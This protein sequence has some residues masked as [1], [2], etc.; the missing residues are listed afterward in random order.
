ML[1]EADNVSQPQG[2]PHRR[3]FVGAGLDLTLWTGP[4]KGFQGFQICYRL[5]GG[6]KVLTFQEGDGYSHHNL[7]DGESSCG[8]FKQ[9]PL[10]VPDGVLDRD[11]LLARFLEEAAELE[12]P[13]LN[14][15]AEKLREYPG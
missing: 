2:E 8:R 10:L 12:V 9:T 1:V 15:V 5:P 11:G 13:I 7:D 4:E 3:W 14:Y 6:E